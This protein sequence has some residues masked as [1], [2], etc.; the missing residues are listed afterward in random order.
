MFISISNYSIK[1]ETYDEMVEFAKSVVSE[2]SKIQGCKQM[3][4]MRTG[5]DS[6]SSIA[7]YNS[8]EDA[9]AATPQIQQ[10]FSRMAEFLSAPPD[11]NIHEAIIYEQF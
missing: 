2:V 10:I 7:A 1:P 8:K 5:E 9:E 6:A 4:I 11:R 3:I